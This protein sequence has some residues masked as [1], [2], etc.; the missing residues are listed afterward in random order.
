VLSGKDLE[1]ASLEQILPTLNGFAELA[2]KRALIL[3]TSPKF[4][5]V[6]KHLKQSTKGNF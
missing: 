6:M 5:G 1:P 4:K 3:Y 2:L